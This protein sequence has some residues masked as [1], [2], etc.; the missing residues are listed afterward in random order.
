MLSPHFCTSPSRKEIFPFQRPD[1]SIWRSR[2]HM[3]AHLE[4]CLM[5]LPVCMFNCCLCCGGLKDC[6]VSLAA[7]YRPLRKQYGHSLPAQESCRL[8]SLDLENY[9]AED[10]CLSAAVE[11]KDCKDGGFE[12]LGTSLKSLLSLDHSLLYVN[13]LSMQ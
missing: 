3:D 6:S 2:E 11:N 7:P 12:F 13:H 8:C 1:I 4:N 9:L 10:H 5:F